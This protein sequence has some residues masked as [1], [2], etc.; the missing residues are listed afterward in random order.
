MYLISCIVVCVAQKYE[1]LVYHCV[2]KY[3]NIAQGFVYV[4]I[5]LH[6]DNFKEIYLQTVANQYY[7]TSTD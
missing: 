2:A 6:R 7:F 5:R 4:G 1:S 3:W